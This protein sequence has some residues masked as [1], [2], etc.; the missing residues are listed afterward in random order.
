MRIKSVKFKENAISVVLKNTLTNKEIGWINKPDLALIESEEPITFSSTVRP[1]C[2]FGIGHSNSK[3]PFYNKFTDA[4][5]TLP[6]SQPFVVAGWGITKPWCSSG[7]H[8][9]SDQLMYGTMRMISMEECVGDKTEAAQ[10]S[11][12]LRNDEGAYDNQ[13]NS[14]LNEITEF[15][16]E[17]KICVVPEPSQTESVNA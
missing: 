16:K 3:L 1:I 12:V 7:I 4:A 14:I 6:N 10:N 5:K 2:L 15:D 9:A 11:R 8:S 17:D 13:L